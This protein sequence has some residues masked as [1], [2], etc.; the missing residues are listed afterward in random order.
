MAGISF[1][2]KI[3]LSGAISVILMVGG[4]IMFSNRYE[5]RIVTLEQTDREIVKRLE[6]LAQAD[7]GILQVIQVN[8]QFQID[9]RGRVWNDI[10]EMRAALNEMSGDLKATNAIM[11]R[12]ERAIEQIN[13]DQRQAR[14]DRKN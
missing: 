10:K 3:T 11:L 6:H 9:Q 13:A 2:P 4:L 1:D 5:A 7:E 12:V 8:R 14:N